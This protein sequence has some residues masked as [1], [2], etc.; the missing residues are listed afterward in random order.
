MSDSI[1]LELLTLF[2]NLALRIATVF[3]R[4]TVKH[5]KTNVHNIL[6]PSVKNFPKSAVDY[7]I[8]TTEL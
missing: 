8:Q 2:K 3:R 7:K 4:Y 1:L 6:R 5:F